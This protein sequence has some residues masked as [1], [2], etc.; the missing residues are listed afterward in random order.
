M[1]GD[2]EQGPVNSNT[3]SLGVSPTASQD[4]I[5]ILGD[6]GCDIGSNS[7]AAGIRCSCLAVYHRLFLL[8]MSMLD[9]L[10]HVGLAGLSLSAFVL[11]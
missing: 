9:H 7:W 1:S 4:V 2:Q 10:V 5:D 11:G 6:D 8:P 3:Q